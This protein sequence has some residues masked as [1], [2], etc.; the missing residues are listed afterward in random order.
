MCRLYI[1]VFLCDFE[2]GWNFLIDGERMD[3]ID[4]DNLYVR[5]C[6]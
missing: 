2:R 6:C 5:E 1:K 3:V 4:R